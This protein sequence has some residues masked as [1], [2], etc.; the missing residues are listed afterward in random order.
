MIREIVINGLSKVSKEAVLAR[1]R[2]KP[3]QPYVQS[4]L[5]QDKAAIEDMGFFQAVDVRARQLEVGNWQ[6]VV[7][8]K[9]W[10]VVKEIRVTG[11]PAIST[12]GT[13]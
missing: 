1:M 2:T 8:V 13:L 10:P 9:E 12:A 5:D 7:E 4:T 3:G 6:I 11:H